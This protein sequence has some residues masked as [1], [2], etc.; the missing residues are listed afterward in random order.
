MKFD[1]HHFPVGTVFEI[2][3]DVRFGGKAEYTV[4]GIARNGARSYVLKTGEHR[5]HTGEAAYNIEHVKR[6]IHRG[7]GEVVIDHGYHGV[8]LSNRTKLLEEQKM[9]E[10]T[11]PVEVRLGYESICLF[12]PRKRNYNTGSLQAVLML[13]IQKLGHPGLAVDYSR[14]ISAVFDQSWCTPIRERYIQIICVNRKRL[15]KWLKQNVNRFLCKLDELVKIEEEEARV[16]YERDCQDWEDDYLK[17]NDY[18]PDGYVCNFQAD[19]LPVVQEVLNKF[20]GTQEHGLELREPLGSTHPGGGSLWCRPDVDDLRGFWELYDSI[21]GECPK[22]SDSVDSTYED[23]EYLGPSFEDS[24][25]DG[26]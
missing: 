24:N 1:T 8:G 5:E 6:V 3:E 4:T 9:M 23:P 14:R 10:I 21:L 20:P 26:S 19:Q 13:E 16:S 17:S 18:Y 11:R 12:T 2:N 7:S 25:V 22:A 15:R